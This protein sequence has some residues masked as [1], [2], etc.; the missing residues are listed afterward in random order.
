MK[1]IIIIISSVYLS[2]TCVTYN[3][4]SRPCLSFFF[5]LLEKKPIILCRHLNYMDVRVYRICGN[6]KSKPSN[7]IQLKEGRMDYFILVQH[8]T[9]AVK[10]APPHLIILVEQSVFLHR[11][12]WENKYHDRSYCWLWIPIHQNLSNS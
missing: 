4:A 12:L 3:I 2:S 11:A 10:R 5:F 1:F 7:N 6:I 8:G 9:D